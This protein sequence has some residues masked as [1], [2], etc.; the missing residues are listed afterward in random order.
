MKL[1]EPIV[2]LSNWCL[3]LAIQAREASRQLVGVTRVI[4][5]RWL[6]LAS[7]R[8][9]DQIPQILEANQ[10]DID[11]AP[12]YGLNSA[13]IDRLQLSAK[14]IQ[15]MME[16]LRQVASLPDPVGQIREGS[17]RPNGLEVRKVAVPLG[18]IFFLYESRP[19]VTVDAAALSVKSGNAVILRGGKEA[20]HS[21]LAIYQI[22]WETL[23]ECGLPPNAVQ[24]VQ[25]LNRDAVG[26]LLKL[27]EF[28]DLVIPRGGE[29]LIRRVVSEATMPVLKHY[30]GN[31]HVYVDQDA[32]LDMAEQIIINSKCQRP[33][34]CN[35]MESLLVHAKIA[36][37]FLPKIGEALSAKGVEIRG[38]E[39]TRKFLQNALSASESDYGAEYLD[40]IVSIKIVSDLDS[41]IAHINRYGSKHTDAI[42]T[43]DLQA[44]RRFTQAVDS[45]AVMV[46]ASTRFNDGFELGLG[47]EIGIS[48]DKFH[49]R[50]PC[51]L[52]ELMTYKYVVIGDGQIRN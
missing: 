8:L 51:G 4:K 1:H 18:V 50:G 10:R 41:A 23:Q 12:E 47:A 42:I 2:D 3:Q 13:A 29:S 31:C 37:S 11:T 48:T 44:A 7:E 35:A 14:R 52:N 17:I 15:S 34:V 43:K 40:L 20:Y 22:L 49:A 36:D 9:I 26:H 16:G 24:L 39:V 5:D 25:T 38:C 19:N 45:S 28:I 21:N 6:H 33:G 30:L 46:N 32:N 27:N